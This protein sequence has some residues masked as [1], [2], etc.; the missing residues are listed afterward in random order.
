MYECTLVGQLI[1]YTVWRGSALGCSS[2]ISLRHGRFVTTGYANG[3]CNGGAVFARIINGTGGCFTSQLIV[4]TSVGSNGESV[5]CL[6]D[7][8]Q[9]EI[10][11]NSTTIS[12]ISG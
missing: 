8:G 4:N 3:T 12:L 2:G 10:P 11:V 1:Q 9:R 5:Q 7:D 6:Y